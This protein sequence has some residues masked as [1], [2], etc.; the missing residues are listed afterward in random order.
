MIILLLP[1]WLLVIPQSAIA[2]GAILE[3]L[4]DLPA[5]PRAGTIQGKLPERVDLSPRMPLARSQS[6]TSTCVSWAATYA[7]ASFVLRQRGVTSGSA[8]ALALSPA[9]TYN[10]VS[11]DQ[12]CRTGT[13]AALTL[14]LLRDVGALPL[15]E[16]AFDGGWCGRQP[17]QAELDRAKQFRIRGWT[18]LDASAPQRVKEQ[19]ARGAPVIFSM[20]ITRKMQALRGDTVLEE[21]D[22]PGEGHAMVVVGYDDARRAFLVQNSWGRSWGA[23]GLGWFGYEFW[24]R[25]ARVGFVIE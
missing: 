25:N 15:D 3:T 24:K 17:S 12:W 22:A 20:R 5:A 16:F 1:A 14:D 8:A 4:D 6:A 23:N 10:Q 11:R 18:A 21:D 7:A 19:L 2:Q 13:K 9:F